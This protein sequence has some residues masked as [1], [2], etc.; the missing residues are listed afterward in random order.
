MTVFGNYFRKVR[1]VQFLD[2]NK[3][4]IFS[5]IRAHC[6]AGFD[7]DE[8]TLTVLRAVGGTQVARLGDW[9]ISDYKPGTYFVVS[10]S[11]FPKMFTLGS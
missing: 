7:G 6:L 8:P 5:E 2:E 1:A 3:D 10:D 9:I 4:M 11:E